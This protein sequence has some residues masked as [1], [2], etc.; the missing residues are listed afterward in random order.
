MFLDYFEVLRLS[1]CVKVDEVSDRYLVCTAHYKPIRD[2][3]A[4]FKLVGDSKGLLQMLQVC[5]HCFFT[6]WFGVLHNV[7]S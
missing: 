2:E 4:Q 5:L 3:L 1:V 6:G 7:S